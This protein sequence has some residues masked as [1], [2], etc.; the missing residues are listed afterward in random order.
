[1]EAS[2]VETTSTFGIAG[3]A[4]GHE[5]LRLVVRQG[6]LA[7]SKGVVEPTRRRSKLCLWL[8]VVAWVSSLPTSSGP[9]RLAMLVSAVRDYVG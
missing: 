7:S 9:W 3:V 5:M 8:G 2:F 1:M 6:S 4:V